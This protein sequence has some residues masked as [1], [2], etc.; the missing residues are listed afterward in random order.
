MTGAARSEY[1]DRGFGFWDFLLSRAVEASTPTRI[2]LWRRAISHE[3][4]L[5]QREELGSSAFLQRLGSSAYDGLDSRQIV[6]LTS[7]VR[8][9]GSEIPLHLPMLDF[10]LSASPHNDTVV[11]EML[12]EL[13]LRGNLYR[14]GRSYH[15][16]GATPVASTALTSILARAQLLGPLVDHRWISHQLINGYCALRISTDTTRNTHNHALVA[17]TE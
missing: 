10:A 5:Q 7:W 9:Q 16:I 14:S 6:S 15:F 1:V 2:A 13:R 17:T 4:P 8:V 3:E 11:V 12:D